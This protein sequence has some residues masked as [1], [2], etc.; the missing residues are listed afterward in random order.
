MRKLILPALV[1][2]AFALPAFAQVNIGGTVGGAMGATNRM[3]VGA[4]LGSVGAQNGMGGSLHSGANLTSPPVGNT[5][6]SAAQNVGNV[7]NS[8]TQQ[9]DDTAGRASQAGSSGVSAGAD[10][11]TQAQGVVS[12]DVQDDVSCTANAGV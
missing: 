6:S 2:A 10:Q 11:A 9:A 3:Q 12:S 4:P 1:G 7:A 8:A 5:V